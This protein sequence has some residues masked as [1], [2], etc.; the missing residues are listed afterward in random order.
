[1][2]NNDDIFDVKKSIV[3]SHYMVALVIG[4]IRRNMIDIKMIGDYILFGIRPNN[5]VIE[6]LNKANKSFS[7]SNN[8]LLS[9]VKL[10]I[11]GNSWSLIRV[12][13]KFELIECIYK[14]TQNGIFDRFEMRGASCN[15]KDIAKEMLEC[16]FN[17]IVNKYFFLNNRECVDNIEINNNDNDNYIKVRFT[18]IK[19]CDFNLKSINRYFHSYSHPVNGITICEC[20]NKNE[21][22]AS[23][24]I[25]SYMY[26]IFKRI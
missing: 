16:I 4:S 2:K 14:M 19:R 18:Y 7:E 17:N 26:L 8:P 11:D 25:D 22:I 3:N 10:S 6:D 5:A 20:D 13:M 24:S 1:M 12:K 9:D 21:Y 23:L 15:D